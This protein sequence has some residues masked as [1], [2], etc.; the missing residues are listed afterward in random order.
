MRPS[1]M[2]ETLC[3]AAC[4]DYTQRWAR[5]DAVKSLLCAVLVNGAWL[6]RMLV[7]LED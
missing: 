4:K 6:G 2:A 7:M 1:M 5:P 3:L